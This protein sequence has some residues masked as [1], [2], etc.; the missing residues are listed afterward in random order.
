MY[1]EVIQAAVVCVQRILEAP[2]SVRVGQLGIGHGHELLPCGE[3]L[4]GLVRIRH[5]YDSVEL[6]SPDEG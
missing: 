4:A 1:A 2:E 3:A 5:L 6:R